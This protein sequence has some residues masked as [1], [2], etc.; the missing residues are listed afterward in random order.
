[1]AVTRLDTGK[2]IFSNASFLKIT[3]YT[4]ED[5]IGADTYDIVSIVGDT[6]SIEPDDNEVNAI[7]SEFTSA[8]L[9]ENIILGNV[10]FT[11]NCIDFQS[12]IMKNIMGWT[13]DPQVGV[14]F[15][16]TSYKDLWAMV[17]IGFQNPATPNVVIP[18]LKLSSR[19]IINTLKT[20]V[21]QG[22]ISGTA[23]AAK[24]KVTVGSNSVTQETTISFVPATATVSVAQ[25][26]TE[27]EGV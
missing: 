14:S 3:P 25:N 10:N 6:I 22:E 1:M 19:A 26:I 5:T 18:K 15:A 13:V 21:S 24:M 20:G 11:C 7:E 2:V 4:D 12:D 17:E 9:Y 8:P 23:Y 16:P 27:D